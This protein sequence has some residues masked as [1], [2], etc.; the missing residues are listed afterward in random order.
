MCGGGGWGV[1]LRAS[2]C[3]QTK[4]RGRGCSG[5]G[6]R[7]GDGREGCRAAAATGGRRS[8]GLA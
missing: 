1:C 5:S 8:L 7:N 6:R 3:R 2:V 4:A